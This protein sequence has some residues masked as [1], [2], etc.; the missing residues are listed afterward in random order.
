MIRAS[1]GSPAPARRWWLLLLTAVVLMFVYRFFFDGNVT[2]KQ[3]FAIV[4]WAF[5]IVAIVTIPLLLGT[6]ALKGAW[7]EDPGTVIAANLTLVLDRASTPKPLYVLAKQLDLFGFWLVWL[8]ASGF[9]VALRKPTGSALWGV[10]IPW[11]LLVAIGV[12]WA[13]IF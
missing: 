2:F 6:M 5:L 4:L 13:A 3:S 9:G 7:N 8:L 11:L 12:G 1:S 10:A